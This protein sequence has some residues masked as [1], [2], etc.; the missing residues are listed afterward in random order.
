VEGDLFFGCV[1][2]GQLRRV[3]LNGQR[4][5]VAGNPVTVLAS[6]NGAIYSMESAPD[7]RIYFSDPRGIYRLALS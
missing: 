6:P 4:T 1:N 2:D 5:D 7:G 3:A